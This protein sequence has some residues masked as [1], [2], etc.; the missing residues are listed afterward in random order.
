[1]TVP[2]W[3]SQLPQQTLVQGFQ[4]SV[5]GK[6]LT[7]AMDTGPGK[8]RR[9]G[10]PVRPVTCA[11]MVDADNR[12]LFD[13]FFDEDCVGG[14]LPFLIPDQQLDGLLLDDQD[15]LLLETEDGSPL[16]LESWW[17]CCFGT[18]EPATSAVAGN[19]FSIQFD[20][21]VLP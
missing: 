18:S 2:V 19:W 12:A 13:V 4:A 17:L 11:I 15:S 9:R 21:L 3:P 7:T 6:R 20:L 8:Q 5:R 16:I 1:M 14:T 10:A